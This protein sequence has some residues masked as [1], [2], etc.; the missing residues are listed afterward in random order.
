[1]CGAIC[2]VDYYHL[3]GG[4]STGCKSC[5]KRRIC[6]KGHDTEFC[7]RAEDYKC[8]L[9]TV[10]GHIRR[11]Y[12]M[13][14]DEYL[15]L[16]TYQSG[17]CAICGRALLINGAFSVVPPTEGDPTRA[18]VDHR[19]VTKKTKPQPDKKSTV[20]GL[21]CGGRYA[22]C[23]AKLG[24]VDNVE[25]LKNAVAYLENPPAQ[26]LFKVLEINKRK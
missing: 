26:T 24:R 16:F 13:S 2:K 12:G 11:A 14:L 6:K 19:H 22:G 1:M 4:F 9:C 8:K 3:K 7:G 21:L 18:E 17:N 10:E 20:R 15:A 23:N 5:I 25:W